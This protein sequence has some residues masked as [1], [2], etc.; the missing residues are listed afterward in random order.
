MTKEEEKKPP[1]KKETTE[2]YLARGGKITRLPLVKQKYVFR[3]LR[4]NPFN[5]NRKKKK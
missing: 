5:F 2:E 1:P 3:F 4:K